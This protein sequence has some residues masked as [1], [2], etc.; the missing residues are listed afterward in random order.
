MF[1]SGLD[2]NVSDNPDIRKSVLLVTS[3]ASHA[4]Q[5]PARINMNDMYAMDSK[6]YFTQ[7][8]L[9]VAAALEGIF[10]SVFANRMVPEGSVL[11][12]NR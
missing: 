6:T 9:P 10:P 3:N 1:A 11:M 7:H 5:V 2:L 4:T 8:Y 12:R